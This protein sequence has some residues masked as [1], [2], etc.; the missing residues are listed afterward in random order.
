MKNIIHIYGASGSGTTTLGRKICDGLGYIFIDTDDYF[1]MPT[2]PKYQIKRDKQERIMLMK[3]VIEE[4]DNVVISGSLV[5]WGDELIP[6]F[7]LVIRLVTDTAIRIERLKNRE[8]ENFGSRIDVGGD[9]YENHQQFIGWAKN[10]DNGD[11]NMRSKAKHDV[12][13]KLLRCKQIVLNGADKL[14]YNVAAVKKEII[15][16]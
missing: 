13:E 6:L 11:V 16:E 1:W 5:D 14:E 9:M 12:W 10:Y 7:T 4:S 3:E 15:R 8:R 2:D